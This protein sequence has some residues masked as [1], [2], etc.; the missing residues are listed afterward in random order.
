MN[1]GRKKKSRPANGRRQSF[2]RR[3]VGGAYDPEAPDAPP[4]AVLMVVEF[5]SHI[6]RATLPTAAIVPKQAARINAM[7]TAY[8][9]A[10]AASSSTRSLRTKF[11]YLRRV[12]GLSGS[13]QLRL[14][15]DGLAVA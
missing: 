3:D 5:R 2:L 10:V 7:T 9:T 14:A 12:K 15:H 6:S 4:N 11:I 8:S 13:V 1:D